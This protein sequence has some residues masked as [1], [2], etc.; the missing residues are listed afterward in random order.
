VNGQLDAY[1][2]VDKDW[3]PRVKTASGDYPC[4]LAYAD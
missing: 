4:S 1:K 3:P 2:V